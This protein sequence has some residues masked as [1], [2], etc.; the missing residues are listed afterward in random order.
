MMASFLSLDHFL[1]LT[2]IMF[3]ER[4]SPTPVGISS[5]TFYVKKTMETIIIYDMKKLTCYD[6]KYQLLILY[7]FFTII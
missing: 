4:W 5:R 3:M 6:K 7:G 1:H 2:E